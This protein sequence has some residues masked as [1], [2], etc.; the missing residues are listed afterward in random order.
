[1]RCK[2]QFI[3]LVLLSFNAVAQESI[4]R[5]V[6]LDT[7]ADDYSLYC[8]A[9]LEGLNNI[10]TIDAIKTSFGKSVKSWKYDVSTG[11]V[12]IH[13]KE[14]GGIVGFLNLKFTIGAATISQQLFSKARTVFVDEDKGLKKIGE[15]KSVN[16]CGKPMERYHIW[17]NNGL[18]VSEFDA[19]SNCGDGLI[20]VVIEYIPKD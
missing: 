10:D 19:T 4:T 14:F 1:M 18:L 7:K 2:V 9:K 11:Q 3:L 8:R 17:G 6:T 12:L 16:F 20:E 5:K 13:P 15:I